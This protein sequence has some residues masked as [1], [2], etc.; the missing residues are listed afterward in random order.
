[1]TLHPK[2]NN[3]TLCG[4]MLLLNLAD[5]DWFTIGCNQAVTINVM[6]FFAKVKSADHNFPRNKNTKMY[7]KFCVHRNQT[8]FIFSWHL[9]VVQESKL[10]ISLVTIKIFQFLFD[11][12]SSTFPPIV[13]KSTAFVYTKLGSL[14]KYNSYS[15]DQSPH[16]TSGDRLHISAQNHFRFALGGNIFKCGKTHRSIWSLCGCFEYGRPSLATCRCYAS[17]DNHTSS[18]AVHCT[19]LCVKLTDNKCRPVDWETTNWSKK[20]Q[21]QNGNLQNNNNFTL[22]QPQ[23]VNGFQCKDGSVVPD[24]L[25]NDLVSDCGPGQEDEAI[26]N[27]VL[28]GYSFSCPQGTQLPCR[29]NF[30]ICYNISNIC[31]YQLNECQKLLH[32]R[33]G[34]HLQNC[35]E[36]ECNMMH[37]CTKYYCIP[38]SYICDGKGDCPHHTD[39][40][41]C[42]LTQNCAGLYRCEDSNKCIHLNDVCN[43]WY[44]CVLKEDESFC[45]LSQVVCPGYCK[46]LI[47]AISCQNLKWVD[48]TKQNLPFH[49][50]NVAQSDTLQLRLFFYHIKHLS[51]LTLKQ[52]KL[53][54]LCSLLPSTQHA[55]II[56]AGLNQITQI[57]SQCFKKSSTIM[58]IKLNNNNL[59]QIDNLAF[60][61]LK[62]LAILD[63]S[64]NKLVKLPAAFSLGLVTVQVLFL[65]GNILELCEDVTIRS[66]NLKH[67]HASDCTMC[68]LLS[69]DVQCLMKKPW[70]FSC[71]DLLPG[72]G[73]KICFYVESSSIIVISG[74]SLAFRVHQ[75]QKN[76]FDSWAFGSTVFSVNLVDITFGIYLTVMW[77]QDTISDEIFYLYEIKWKSSLLCFLEFTLLLNFNFLSPI[78]LCFLSL[79]RLMVVLYPMNSKFKQTQFVVKKISLLSIT[80]FFLSLCCTMD[81][82]FHSIQ[83]PFKLCSPFV[84]PT[85]SVI[86]V[87]ITTWAVAL[88]QFSSIIFITVVYVKLLRE[89]QIGKEKLKDQMSKQRSN[90]AI[91]YQLVIVTATNILCWIP[92]CVVHMISMFSE[93]YPIDMVLWT[94]IVVMPLNSVVN[95]VVFTVIFLRELYGK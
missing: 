85:N 11:A 62:S 32:C 57:S 50:I 66:E 29:D 61:G 59:S 18:K 74:V 8:C 17:S 75:L 1:M 45:S 31:S 39:E 48:N 9:S 83:V 36:F 34:E 77:V 67:L 69:E 72:L 44:D 64:F 82:K 63:V 87:K 80:I 88:L 13:G 93:T 58:I 41:H 94:S 16:Q 54:T 71:T 68:C 20:L 70:F 60:Y 91:I 53:Q 12:V 23:K 84:D 38:W 55:V 47:V 56:D 89:L 14:Y 33:T 46:C 21:F 95:P 35:D 22:N 81:M 7:D 86:I 4:A 6:C 79:E 42:G 92:S 26:V 43:G 65:E 37:K 10:R 27:S 73:I 24:K 90:R 49:V 15:I 76:T 78:L 30:P 28:M 2:I 40:K 51:I 5:P 19:D 52:N 3:I 25:M